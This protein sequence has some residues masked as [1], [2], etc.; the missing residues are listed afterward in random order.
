M[1]SGPGAAGLILLSGELPTV[2]SPDVCEV[3]QAHGEDSPDA[4][5]LTQHSQMG[6]PTSKWVRCK[7][8]SHLRATPPKP[9]PSTI[10]DYQ[11]PED[12]GEE[13]CEARGG[14]RYHRHGPEDK[15]CLE[16][17]NH[18]YPKPPLWPSASLTP[19]PAVSF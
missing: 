15:E 13:S 19:C 12:T 10:Y 16:R 18:R 2:R 6:F 4:G 5:R 8:H 1:V 11:W 9:G 14:I 17:G 7:N 3:I